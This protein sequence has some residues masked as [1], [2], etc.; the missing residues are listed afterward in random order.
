M[1]V[2]SSSLGACQPARIGNLCLED[3]YLAEPNADALFAASLT[4]S[5]ALAMLGLNLLALE[6]II[7]VVM[8]VAVFG[9]IFRRV[10]MKRSD[11]S[12]WVLPSRKLRG[13]SFLF[14]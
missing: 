1:Q 6:T 13:R 2:S 10:R 8:D 5:A 4:A 14:L 7:M 12:H 3:G 9:R 11:F